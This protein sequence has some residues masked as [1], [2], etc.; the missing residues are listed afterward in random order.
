[1]QGDAARLKAWANGD[2]AAGRA[3]VEENF[4]IVRRFFVTK[5]AD[6]DAEDLIQATFTAGL[7]SVDRFRGDAPFRAY[8]MGVARRV[9]FRFL[10]RKYRDS[11]IDALSESV[12]DLGVSPPSAIESDQR[13]Q[14]LLRALRSLPVDDQVAVELYYWESYRIAEVAVVLELS[15]T[16]TKTRLFRARQQLALTL[17]RLSESPEQL[18]STLDNLE[19]WQA[20]TRAL[21]EPDPEAASPGSP[22]A[23]HHDA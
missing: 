7:E 1:M 8:L 22:T 16:A 2:A 14:L 11:P 19:A 3:L 4:D 12:A 21:I 23:R 5:V 9:L 6:A 13:R 18:R 15:F 17:E 10:S 20:R